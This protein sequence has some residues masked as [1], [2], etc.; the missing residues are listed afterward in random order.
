MEIQVGNIRYIYTFRSAPAAPAG[1]GGVFGLSSE[2]FAKRRSLMGLLAGLVEGASSPQE[3][4]KLEQLQRLLA[5]VLQNLHR[6]PGGK[7]KAKI[8]A[9]VEAAVQQA[10]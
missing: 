3:K 4:E 9:A 5:S 6:V 8:M 10:K 2:E 1:G 7:M